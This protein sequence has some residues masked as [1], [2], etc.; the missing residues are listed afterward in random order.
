M[1]G[2][3]AERAWNFGPQRARRAPVGDVVRRLAELWG[4]ELAWELDDGPHPPEA[5]RLALDSSDAERLLGWRPACDLDTALGL[6]VDWH[7]AHRAGADMRA[8]SQE[9][10]EAVCEKSN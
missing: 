3:G 4:G 6:A 5:A 1:S 10:I 8:V 9:Q 7:R 2:A